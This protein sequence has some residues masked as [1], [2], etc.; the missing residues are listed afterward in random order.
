MDIKYKLGIHKQCYNTLNKT[1][2][3]PYRQRNDLNIKVNEKGYESGSAPSWFCNDADMYYFGPHRIIWNAEM[4][5]DISI[6][7][8]IYD[9]ETA[10]ELMI[11]FTSMYV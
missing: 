7:S 8:S 11:K 6:Y 4:L 5:S 1:S 10:A 9:W 2:R 3:F